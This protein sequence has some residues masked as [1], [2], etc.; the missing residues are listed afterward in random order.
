MTPD[1]SKPKPSKRFYD[2]F[3]WLVTQVS[4]AFTTAPFVLLSFE[5]SFR[6]WAR[7]YFYC[8][9]G[10][11]TCLGFLASPG[12]SYLQKE[13]KKRSSRPSLA[14]VHSQDGAPMLGLP[15]DPEKEV[16]EAIEEIKQELERR[17]QEGQPVTNDVKKSIEDNLKVRDDVKKVVEDKFGIKRGQ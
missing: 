15:N 2:A 5:S 14:R 6:A 10:V 7:V 3:T 11:A 13:I 12:K 8:I 16:S 1:G 9:V 4:F 17:K